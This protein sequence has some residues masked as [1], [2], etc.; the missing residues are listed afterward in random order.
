MTRDLLRWWADAPTTRW[1]TWASP[2]QPITH[3]LMRG[4]I[5]VVLAYVF[6]G[7]VYLIALRSFSVGVVMAIGFVPT[8]G[9]VFWIQS[10]VGRMVNPH[11]NH[12]M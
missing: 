11:H 1:G 8:L 7:I 10:L 9:V 4:L 12:A 2:K 5:D 6:L 3:R